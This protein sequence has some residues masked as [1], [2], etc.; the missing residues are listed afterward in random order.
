MNTQKFVR[1]RLKDD[2]KTAM[3]AR[4]AFQSKVIRVRTP[5]IP[6]SK[7]PI[8]NVVLHCGILQSVLADITNAEKAN[9]TQQ[10][11]ADSSI[12][13]IIQKAVT[14]RSEAATQYTSANRPDLAQTETQ[15]LTILSKYLPTPL[16][17]HEIDV[18][19]Q[20]VLI[21]FDS[22]QRHP[23]QMGKIMKAFYERVEK[24]AVRGDIVAAR[25][26]VLL[27]QKN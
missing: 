24:T 1:D 2:L 20:A 3:K 12:L 13:P 10:F 23:A 16:T 15:E 17:E 18:H 8:I 7:A 19:L 4:D 25:V 27:G 26:K 14:Q 9:P 11:T 5:P 22:S 6:L 21:S